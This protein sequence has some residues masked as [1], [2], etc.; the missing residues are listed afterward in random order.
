[1]YEMSNQPNPESIWSSPEPGSRKPK[2]SRTAI[3]DAAI[4]IADEEGFDAVSMRRVAEHLGVGTMS[5]Y[6]YIRSKDDLMALVDDRLMEEVLIPDGEVPEDWRE[7]LI[8]V[9]T[10]SYRAWTK[11]PWL[12]A[13]MAGIPRLGPNVL[14]HVDQSI[15]VFADLGISPA[16][17]FELTS[18]IDDYTLGF[19]LSARDL[20]AIQEEDWKEL[21]GISAYMAELIDTGELPNLEAFLGTRDEKELF[22]RWR[23][24][25]GEMSE[26]ERFR[27]GLNRLIDG[28]AAGLDGREG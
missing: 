11:R 20:E 27:R 26:E 5:L 4:G 28:I 17:Q 7:A 18:M 14:K 8:E 3:A 10:R 13:H 21:E 22:N 19:V 6:H 24:I 9:A 15:G 1:M 25:A 23:E 12:L 2:L 16:E